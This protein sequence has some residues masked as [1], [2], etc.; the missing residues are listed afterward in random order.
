MSNSVEVIRFINSYVLILSL[1]LH[2]SYNRYMKFLGLVG[3]LLAAFYYV[4]YAP[5]T[6]EKICYDTARKA[7]TDIAYYTASR[8]WSQEDI[9]QRRTEVI[10][11]LGD[12][13]HKVKISSS[14]TKYANGIVES[15]LHMILPT[16]KGYQTQKE[17]HNAECSAYASYT[18]E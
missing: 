17:D 9:C 8:G 1:F 5:V 12:C 11:D 10:L 15:I 6:Q 2:L 3:I 13:I 18:L 7:T 14:V 16:T 4:V